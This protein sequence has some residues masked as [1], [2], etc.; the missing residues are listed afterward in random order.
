MKI[1]RTEVQATPKIDLMGREKY[2]WKVF[3]IVDGTSVTI[4]SGFENS[5]AVAT[6]KA[7]HNAEKY[8]K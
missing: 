6:H 2:F 1:I 7:F 5:F 8:T 4:D 3:Q